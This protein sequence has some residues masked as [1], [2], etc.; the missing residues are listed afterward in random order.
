[1]KKPLFLTSA[2][3]WNNLC[4]SHQQVYARTFVPHDSRPMH[5]RTFVPL[6]S[7]PMSEPLFLSS[8][9]PWV[10][11]CSSRQQQS[12]DLILQWIASVSIM[13]FLPFGYATYVLSIKQQSWKGTILATPS[14]WSQMQQQSWKG[15]ILATPSTWS[16]LQHNHSSHA[17]MWSQMQHSQSSH[18]KHVITEATAE[19]EGNQSSHAKHM[20]TDAV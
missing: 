7:R 3:P 11:L 4:S 1:M 16:Q 10:N 6:V 5:E 14:M 13:V 18:A 17:N 20:I 19:L 9:S 15:T 12:R 2:G 8:A